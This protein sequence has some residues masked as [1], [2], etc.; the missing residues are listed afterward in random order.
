MSKQVVLLKKE[1]LIQNIMVAKNQIRYLY[2]IDI[3]KTSFQARFNVVLQAN[4]QFYLVLSSLNQNTY[5]KQFNVYVSHKKDQAI[6]DC[7]VFGICKDVAIS[8]FFLEA[9]IDKQTKRNSCCQ[10][11]RGILL[12]DNAEIQGKP[13][14]IIDTNNIKAKHALAVGHLNQNH[15]FYLQNKGLT[16]AVAI[17]LL[18]LSYFNV[19]LN[20][21]QNQKRREMLQ[22]KIFQAIGEVD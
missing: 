19:I 22:E 3:L 9:N 12:S 17:K 5:T 20:Q 7:N 6:S 8:R 21:I 10:K 18:L 4:A 11:I 13:N 14:L 15:L 1:K 16:K 2:V